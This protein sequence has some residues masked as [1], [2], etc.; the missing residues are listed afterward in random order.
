MAGQCLLTGAP[1]AVL[2]AQLR[3][4]HAHVAVATTQDSVGAG[5]EHSSAKEAGS[6]M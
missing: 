2:A 5:A 6:H 3:D 4:L 1:S